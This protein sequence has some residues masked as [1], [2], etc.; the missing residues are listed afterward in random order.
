M[1]TTAL[2]VLRYSEGS[3]VV[4]GDRL[5][6]IEQAKGGR[7]TN[8]RQGHIYASLLGKLQLEVRSNGDSQVVFCHVVETSNK[9]PASLRALRV[10][11]LVVGNVVRL[12]P[13]GAH[14]EIC[15]AQGVGTLVSSANSSYEGIIRTEDERVQ[16]V[17]TEQQEPTT[18]PSS[19]FSPGDRVLCRI[20]AMGD[21]RR[22]FLTTAD[23]D[24]GLLARQEE[25]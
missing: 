1:A 12:A 15:I 18:E 25:A 22:Y 9:V 3:T 24:L 19:M 4:P 13:Q 7:G 17:K 16:E 2:P 8:V 6:T 20:V 23:P 14:V 11:Q 10:G 21:N 5:C